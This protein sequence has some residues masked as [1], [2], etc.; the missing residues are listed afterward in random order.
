MSETLNIRTDT[1]AL[2]VFDPAC[3][4]HRL[5]GSA[6]WWSD[7]DEELA[8]LRLGNAVIV[9]LGADGHY[10]VEVDTAAAVT[11]GDVTARVASTGRLFVGPAEELPGGG[12]GPSTGLGGRYF[13]VPSGVFEAGF[14]RGG[15][16][17]VLVTL[18]P[19]TGP[20]ENTATEP[21][22][23]PYAI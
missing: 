22:E 3:L 18:H 23:L 10:T 14:T 1:A 8:E 12:S 19:V 13:A 9:A 2:A 6:D 20:P 4:G 15:P 5:S 16:A 11:R 17:T 21:L 7:P